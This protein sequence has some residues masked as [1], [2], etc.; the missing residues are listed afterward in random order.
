MGDGLEY[1]N[2]RAGTIWNLA[3]VAYANGARIHS[4]SW[5]GACYDIFGSCIPGCT[6]PYDSY[7]RDAD[8]AMWS[9]PD[10]LMV[11]AAG[12][13]A[14]SARP[15]RDRHARGREEPARRR[16]GGPRDAGVDRVLL[17]EP[18]AARGRPRWHRSSPHRAKRPSPPLRTRRSGATTARPA[19]STARRCPHRPPPASRPSCASTTRRGS[20]RPARATPG[21]GSRPR[22]P[23]SRPRS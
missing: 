18:G 19:R 3:D 7:A 8:L 10:L 15:G 11:V 16:L 14:S 9:H 1:L 21:R 23:S 20:T 17:V 12:T 22:A 4:D 13:R 6:A 2:D 5:G